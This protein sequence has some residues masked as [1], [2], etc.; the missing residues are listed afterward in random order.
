MKPLAF[1]C[2]GA[3]FRNRREACDLSYATYAPNHS[4]QK[5]KIQHLRRNKHFDAILEQH[6]R[7]H[8]VNGEKIRTNQELVVKSRGGLVI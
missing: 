8:Q 6:I 7:I 2:I 4:L 1:N 3:D 5:I